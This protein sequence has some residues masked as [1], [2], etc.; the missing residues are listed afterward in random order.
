MSCH[1]H[2]CARVCLYACL[3]VCVGISNNK[4]E[5]YIPDHVFG[6]ICWLPTIPKPFLESAVMYGP[7]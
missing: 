6:A 4:Y 7:G 3:C 1:L 5:G 2:T